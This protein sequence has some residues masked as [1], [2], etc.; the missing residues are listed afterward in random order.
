MEKLD[1]IVTTAIV[2]VLSISVSNAQSKMTATLENPI[3]IIHENS[4]VKDTT[5][6]ASSSVGMYLVPSTVGA[7]TPATFHMK[8]T[9][10]YAEVLL[11]P[12]SANLTAAL[13]QSST[14]NL[15]ASNT[16]KP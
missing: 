5:I 2:L 11:P 4:L 8:G 13:K 6:K 1:K 3:L 16:A 7:V 12:N 10:G 9:A 14:A 15:I